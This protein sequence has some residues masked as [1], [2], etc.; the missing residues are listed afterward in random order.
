MLVLTR[1]SRRAFISGICVAGLLGAG[2]VPAFAE[3]GDP[4]DPGSQEPPPP[5]PFEL[6]PPPPLPWELPPP[7]APDAP[8]PGEVPPAPAPTTPPPGA[9][10]TGDVPPLPVG[11][12]KNSPNNGDVVGVAQP[13]TIV[14]AAPVTDKKA[15]EAAVK[16]T[17]SKPAPGYFYWYTD[18]Q[19][20]WKPTQFW[21]A[22]TD[23]NVNAGGTKWSFKVGDAFVSTVDDA[24]FTMTVT[25]NG[26]VERTMPMSMGKHDK[27]HETKNGTY[28]VS[29]KFQ[30]M[31]MDSST[32]GVPVNSAEG[33][34]LDVY[35]A[36]RLSNSGIFVHAAPW[37]VGQQGRSD[38][39]H[40]CINLSTD[41][42]TW[43][44]NQ[45]HPGDPV[46]VKNSPG[47]PYKDYDGYDDWQRF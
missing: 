36:T 31:V 9:P 15:A 14:F 12:L 10:P 45:S 6:P 23:V 37:S 7:P 43:Y 4:G 2:V 40:G 26:V 44:F 5:P 38:T 27:K 3:P 39:S 13:V 42:A 21:P 28:Y 24:T 20:R 32:Y 30:K 17:T 34:K 22:N 46:I 8:P 19:L 33:Y 47:G 18:Q 16:I 11:L 1:W 35:W 29:E 41:N 25:R